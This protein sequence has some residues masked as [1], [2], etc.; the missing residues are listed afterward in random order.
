MSA[1]SKFFTS[2][3]RRLQHYMENHPVISN[4]VLCL[5]LWIAGDFVSQ[6]YEQK[7]LQSSHH[8]RDASTTIDTS[9]H[10]SPNDN[11][12][13][14]LSHE[15][16]LPFWKEL[17]LKRTAQCASYGAV[18][19]GPIL[20]VWYP[21]LER[22]CVKYSVAARYGLWGAP[23]LKVLA[24]EFLMDP[25]TLL[26]FFGYMN[27][28]EKGSWETFQN[29]MATQFLPSWFTSLAVWPVV[30]L[31]TFRYL[32]TFAQAPVINVCCIVWD[33]FLSHRNMLAKHSE[34]DNQQQEREEEEE[35][36]QEESRNTAKQN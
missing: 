13:T 15:A 14:S 18:V 9:T 28:C 8:E 21:Y 30:L 6:Y 11:N 16:Q 34:K 7:M 19:T 29:K 22:L 36:A 32:P 12:K 25:P 20:A 17:D 26:V 24:D 5:N 4:S 23:V 27:V 1:S 3:C 10:G 35:E 33:A 31:G 2:T